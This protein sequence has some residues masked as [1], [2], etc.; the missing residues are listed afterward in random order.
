MKF[1]IHPPFFFALT[2]G[3]LLALSGQ[4][5]SQEKPAIEPITLKEIPDK[6]EVLQDAKSYEWQVNKNGAI[7]SGNT[8]YFQGALTLFVNGAPFE[9]SKAIRFDGGAA[10]DDGALLALTGKMEA[11]GIE[12]MRHVF[13]DLERSGLRVVDS[14]TNPSKSP[15]NVRIDLKSSFQYPWQDLHGSGGQLLGTKPG[16][17]L[18]PR[19]FGLVVKFSQADGRNDTLFVTSGERDA[20]KPVIS[21]ASNNRELTLSYNLS[22]KPGATASI[23]TWAVQRNLR[24]AGDAET[25][26]RPFY[27]RRRLIRPM[28]AEPLVKSVINFDAQSFPG[29][30]A[31]PFDLEALVNLNEATA[32]RGL[33]RREEDVMWI[34]AENQLAGTLNPEAKLTVSTPFGERKTAIAAVAAIEGGGGIGRKQKVYLRNGE[35][36]AGEVVA[37]N[38]SMKIDEGWDVDE[39]KPEELEL[40]LC[41]I[42]KIDGTPPADTDVFTEFQGG[43]V[44]GISSKNEAIGK[45]GLLSPWGADEVQLAD[46]ARLYYAQGPTP[47]F[48]LER[49]D[50]SRL[51]VFLSGETMNLGELGDANWSDLVRL[52]KVGAGEN[53]T[54]QD[55]LSDIWL[56]FD[57]V[58][59]SGDLPSPACLLA[60]NNVLAGVIKNDAVNLVADRSVTP[61]NPQDVVEIRR[62]LAAGTDRMPVF[63]VE[64]Q[65]GDV[66][67]GTLRERMLTIESAGKEWQVPVQHF[68]GYRNGKGGAQ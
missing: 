28:V 4:V 52:W 37:E 45:L 10:T 61:V 63:E 64:L 5:N 65:S 9:S 33:N 23:L 16:A 58:V 59:D 32:R 1:L 21:F 56:E 17:G 50:G 40:L 24:T 42:S 44:I 6:F 3:I 55:D 12:V 54:V 39:I 35:V 13:F 8:P 2:A 49:T 48:R 20:V 31:E 34:S 68:V 14:F 22:I 11:D 15:K 57:D 25:E 67:T 41:R 47:K 18:G 46:V 62:S 19:D 29:E 43:N 36:W 66:L 26:L 30:G 7:L 60:G 27:T 51:T 38:L 53:V